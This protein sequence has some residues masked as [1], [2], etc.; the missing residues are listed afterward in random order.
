MP[1]AWKG[2]FV[3]RL[4]KRARGVCRSHSSGFQW[5]PGDSSTPRDC[6]MGQRDLGDDVVHRCNFVG[7]MIKKKK[8][9]NDV[10][11]FFVFICAARV[12]GARASVS[13]LIDVTNAIVV[14]AEE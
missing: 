13:S 1:L 6:L 9:M 14:A 3:G 12:Q 10:T 5:L 8:R 7:P 11:H 2:G 4:L